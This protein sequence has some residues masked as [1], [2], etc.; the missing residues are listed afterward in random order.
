MDRL[1]G[2]NSLCSSG[3]SYEEKGIEGQILDSNSHVSVLIDC[4]H[5]LVS[6][7]VVEALERRKA[8]SLSSQARYI[9]SPFVASV[10]DLSIIEA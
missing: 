9:Q 10:K 6:R 3:K 7:Q 1:S 2:G 8:Y 4:R 5:F